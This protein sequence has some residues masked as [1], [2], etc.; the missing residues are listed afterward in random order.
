MGCWPAV[1]GQ[2][3]K[4]G[5]RSAA[6]LSSCSPNPDPPLSPSLNRNHPEALPQSPTRVSFSFNEVAF[7]GLAPWHAVTLLRIRAKRGSLYGEGGQHC[8]DPR[9]LEG[10]NS[11]VSPWQTSTFSSSAS[12]VSAHSPKPNTWA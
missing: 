10:W 3:Q 8:L 11:N 7:S 6:G 1:Q 9:E 12:P 2:L 5:P 4:L